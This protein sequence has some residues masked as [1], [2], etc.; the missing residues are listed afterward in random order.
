MVA[1]AISQNSYLDY[2]G[3]GNA[4]W[5]LKIFDN[6]LYIDDD[7]VVQVF[8]KIKTLSAALGFFLCFQGF[9][10]GQSLSFHVNGG[11]AFPQEQNIESGLET[12]FGFS[13]SIDKKISLS[14]DFSHWKSDV[15]D[16]HPELYDGKISVT[17]FLFSLQYSFLEEATVIPYIFAG[18]G[19]I[20][21]NFEIEDI[22][23]IPEISINQKV[24]NGISFHCGV[25][26]R[27]KLANNLAFLTE[28]VYIYREA[29]AETTITDMNFGVMKDEFSINMSFV[30]LRVGI[31]YFT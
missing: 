11:I 14:L 8:Y 31:K 6:H 19:F 13:L 1:D 17:P 7:N 28:I 24:E 15:S 2:H 25:G 30:V 9:S 29:T 18:T 27:I 16:E 5:S 22:I 21:S 4:Y 3:S 12:G 23:T 10:Y 20:F 26:G